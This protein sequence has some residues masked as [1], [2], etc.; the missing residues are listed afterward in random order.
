[1]CGGGPENRGESIDGRRDAQMRIGLDFDNTLVCYDRAFLEVGREER[2][3]PGD[4]A[5]SKEAVKRWLLERR[6]DGFL[7]E[8]L[9]G[10]VYGCRID[11]AA[12]F[13]GADRFLRACRGRPGVVVLIVSHKTL[14]AHHDPF[15]TDLRTAAMEWMETRHFFTPAGYGLERGDVFFESSREEKIDRIRD[16]RCDVF[17]DDLPEVLSH[18]DMPR[19]C[20]KILFRGMPHGA[21]EQF[22]C[23]DD[24]CDALFPSVAAPA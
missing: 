15:R 1:M 12:L 11:R 7:W 16:A 14:F 3:L 21:L 8:K 24:I 18:A 13:E 5:G 22:H 20:R 4:F 9:Q 17:I 23:W 10:I 2:M 19:N 6:P